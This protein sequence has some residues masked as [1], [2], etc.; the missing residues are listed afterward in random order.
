MGLDVHDPF[1]RLNPFE[2]GMV[3]TCEP[4]IYIPDEGLG[5][6]LENDILITEKGPVDLMENIPM[7]AD[8]I[9]DLMNNRT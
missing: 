8:E 4:A 9:E 7:E 1:D 2:P 3:L 6:R 5:I